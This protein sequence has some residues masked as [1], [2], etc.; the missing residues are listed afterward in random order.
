MTI[1]RT[2][3]CAVVC[4]LTWT[5]S[6]SAQV[7]VGPDLVPPV[8]Q[9][10]EPPP[11]VKPPPNLSSTTQAAPLKPLPHKPGEAQLYGVVTDQ[12]GAVLPGATISLSGESG[13]ARTVVS[14]AQ[15]QY[16]INMAPGS[17]SLTISTKGFKEFATEGLTLNANQELEMDGMLEPAAASP[18]K[19]EVV[20]S[21]VGQV[22]T[23]K[24]EVAGTITAKQ[25]VE[26]PLNGR[27][28]TQLLT[29]AP[30]VSNQTGQDEALVGVKGSVK[31]S[32]NGGRV[33][34]NTFSVD[35]ADVLHAGIHGSEST[36]V[37][38][39]SLDSINELKVLTS[40]YGAQYGRSASGTILVETKSGGSTFHGGAYYFGRNEIFNARN[41][42]D[43]T[44]RAP[45][46]RKN[47]FGYTLGGPLYI[48]KLYPHKD[49]TYFFFSQEFRIEKDPTDNN[50]NQAV[51]SL[52]ERPA[53]RTNADGEQYIGAD[54]SDVCP[55]LPPGLPTITFNPAQFPDCPRV[56][57][58]GNKTFPFNIVGYHDNSNF[59]KTQYPSVDPNGQVLANSGMI[60]LPNATVGC[61]ST[62]G[63]CY[64]FAY[65]Q[66]TYWRQE[67]F[68][69]DH[70]IK[71]G[72]LRATFRYIHD[73][74]D[75]TEARPIWGYVRNSFPTVQGRLFG[76]G[77]S[78]VAKL[79]QT[80]SPTMLNELVV[81]YTASHISMTTQ[82]APGVCI[83]R[84]AAS[85]P[86]LINQP[87]NQGYLFNNCFGGT[88]QGDG[89]CAGGKL[90]G[91]FLAPGN[92]AYG[93]GFKVDPGYAPW[94]LSN[95][96]YALRDDL[97]KII[98]R[99]TLQM[100]VQVILG[101]RNETNATNGPNTG[102][103]QGVLGFS[104]F[105][106]LG[107]VGN[108]YADLLLGY[109]Q[110]Y[111]QDSAQQKYHNRYDIIEPYVQDDWRVNHKL[112]LNLG[113]RFSL[114]GNYHENNE[115]A[116]NW[117]PAKY[118]DPGSSLTFAQDGR[119]LFNKKAVPAD[120][121]DPNFAT[122]TLPIIGN[123]LVRCGTGGVPDTCMQPHR[124]NAAPRVGFAY[125]L[126]GD[127]KTSIR[128]GYGIFFEHGT[129]SEANTGSLVGSAPLNMTMT[130][131]TPR[132]IAQNPAD[133]SAY[134]CIGG[135]AGKKACIS[136]TGAYPVD[137]TSIPRETIWPYVQQWSLGVQRELSKGLVIGL[138]YVGS[139]GTHLTAVLQPNAFPEAPQ[140]E[141]TGIN[142]TGNPYGPHQPII[143]SDA[144]NI[145][146]CTN[147]GSLNKP[148]FVI[149]GVTINSTQPAFMNLLAACEAANPSNLLPINA[150]RPFR[151]IQKIYS[152]ENTADS[153]YHAFQ[154]TLR[155]TRGPVT[156]DLSYSYSH[157][158]DDS[159]DRNDTTITNPLVVSANKASS[160][161]DQ[162]HLLNVSY[163]WTLPN[164]KFDFSRVG[165]WAND[166]PASDAPHEE[167]FLERALN[168]T[169][170]GWQLSG[171]T[172]VQSGIPFTVINAGYGAL[173]ISLPDNAGV[174]S[175]ITSVA[176]FPD[177][178]A[179]IH[180]P[181]PIG[182]ENP[183]SFGPVLGNAAAFAAPRGLTF[184]NAGRNVLNNPSRWNF[185][186][187]L[188]KSLKVHEAASIEFRAEVFN[189]FNH[190]QF[191]VYDPSPNFGNTASNTITC[192]GTESYSA[193]GDPQTDCLTGNAFLHPVNAHRPRTVQFGLKMSF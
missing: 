100:G 90:S 86:D 169:L 57:A 42:F 126:R 162:R 111:Q 58:Q 147:I 59:L 185:D 45:L 113:I 24:A 99:H 164:F 135:I 151:G 129:G 91:I 80:I 152:L 106:A 47:D 78:A 31:F 30:G 18:E 146:D 181:A 76:P 180:D 175:G 137:V 139:K 65:A 149:N 166:Q 63:S 167:S 51:P 8:I 67:L 115:Q 138:G 122:L 62:V 160:N 5:C 132:A 143:N 66:P 12:S 46:Y 84:D 95:P 83:N 178:V 173:G 69:I 191:R 108:E 23:E 33:E 40:N 13:P 94:Q 75:T 154:A 70:D 54:F 165:A 55:E 116:F 114:F 121:N 72:R 174:A 172:T 189:I 145:R 20:G 53:V 176:S 81:S 15:G 153:N 158:I 107:T 50:F 34:Y 43:Q 186:M 170:G 136:G 88:R 28:F 60:P 141:S 190:T 131:L 117:D 73:S 96:T 49:R 3:F 192:Y 7:P 148:R 127:G 171:V 133:V 87:L 118:V 157:S 14:N 103:L 48:P 79:T 68:R 17:Y 105:A 4:L 97:S 41:Y 29:F 193:A 35:G 56:P 159:S 102:D 9:L 183:R 71:P 64:D 187:T 82:T 98:G 182:A 32:V 44:T 109:V 156:V 39:P 112:T 27:N 150:Y 177:I 10:P 93:G 184:G 128:G 163:L 25:V 26:T 130:Q 52:A 11:G 179:S 37:V 1:I 61:N 38:Y 85:C 124:F 134:P 2:G 119:V 140:Q 142:L 19:V 104:N 74:W 6:V 120:S 188:L 89:S 22:E 110:S 155:R 123:G 168:A 21:T 144:L 125:D 77:T 101:Q 161:F 16:F 36:L 92:L